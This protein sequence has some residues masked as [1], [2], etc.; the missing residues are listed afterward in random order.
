MCVC[1]C[2]SMC[3]C[4]FVAVCLFVCESVSLVCVS[5]CMCDTNNCL[6]GEDQQSIQTC[7]DDVFDVINAQIMTH[8]THEGKK[9][10]GTSFIGH[11]NTLLGTAAHIIYWVGRRESR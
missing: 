1:V 11:C 8:L 10:T 9:K 7:I 3:L 5:V 6:R 2:V 4:V